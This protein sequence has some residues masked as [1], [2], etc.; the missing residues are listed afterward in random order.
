MDVNYNENREIFCVMIFA[1]MTMMEVSS[2][3]LCHTHKEDVCFLQER[4]P[5]HRSVRLTHMKRNKASS[6][7][8]YFLCK[9]TSII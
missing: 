9:K 6:R 5:D 1:T 2:C 7:V 4:F 3:V 8:L